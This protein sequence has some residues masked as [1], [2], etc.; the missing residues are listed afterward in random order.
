MGLAAARD[1]RVTRCVG[2]RCIP[3]QADT[4]SQL[5]CE[6][7]TD[8]TDT[9][10]APTYDGADLRD[11]ERQERHEHDDHVERLQPSCPPHADAVCDACAGA[12]LRA[13]RG[14]RRNQLTPD[15]PL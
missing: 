14:M 12:S 15:R 3:A 2:A 9:C 4:G 8:R 5:A 13:Q 6:S 1:G 11:R 10:D 7:R